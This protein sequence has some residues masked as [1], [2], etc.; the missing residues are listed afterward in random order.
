MTKKPSQLGVLDR[1]FVGLMLVVFAGVIIHAPVTIWLGT[2]FPGA[3]LL[4]KAWKEVLIGAAAAV[5]AVI[6]IRRRRF[7]VLKSPWMLLPAAYVLVHVL[8]VP[9]YFSNATATIAGLLIDLRFVIYFALIVVLVRLYPQF[10]HLFLWVFAIGAAVVG[11]FALLQVFV[12]PPDFLTVLGYGDLTISPYLTVDENPDYVRINS[13]LRG[14][15]PLGAFALIGLTLAAAY[16]LRARRKVHGGWIIAGSV[17]S[18]TLIVALWASYS[19]SALV[20]AAV[21]VGLV[22]LLTVGRRITRGAWVAI[23]VVGLA[24]LGGLYAARDT[25]FVSNVI[26]H[27]NEATGAAVNSNEGHVDSLVDGLDRLVH[28]PLGAGV[29]STGSASLYTDTPVIIENQ[30]LFIGHE[31]GWVGLVVF[32]VLFVRILAES[33]RRRGDW[34]ALAVFGSGIGLALIGILLPVWVDDTVAIIWWGLA[35]LAIGGVYERT[36]DKK[37]KRTA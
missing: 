9:L 17:V 31:A 15:N 3:E 28:Q 8:L 13:T 24:S 2:V 34:V 35:G 16:W 10:R 6:V 29:G 26:L 33:W 12:L 19:R 21:A 20:A 32:M 36:I 7:D 4:L 27:D 18:L 11:I 37:T 30:Y 23:F 5:A 1:L 22:L 14:P 25:S